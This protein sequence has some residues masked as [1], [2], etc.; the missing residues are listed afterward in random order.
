MA[1]ADQLF[2]RFG[3]EVPAGTV[4]FY[5]NDP[6]QEM[7][8]IQE[9]KVKIS[10]KVRNT[11]KTLAVLGK[12]EFFGE[13]AILNNKPRSA[14]AEV[15]EDS[16][17]LVIDRK[18]FESMIR[19]NAEI[20]LRI[21]KK[22]AARLQEADNQIENLMIRDNTA[23]V[24]DLLAR[25]TKDR[26]RETDQGVSLDVTFDDLAGMAGMAKDQILSILDKLVR[27][28]IIDLRDGQILITNR[29]HLDRF[30]KYLEMKEM[31]GEL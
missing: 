16:K 3:R 18:T 1:G 15:I 28:Q 10:K 19:G 25:L 4:L 30:M 22:L 14:T 17:I 12:G 2:Q 11:E 7:F 5:E 20:A 8:I 9:G 26:G 31:F 24:V 6:G 29:E 27:V 21:I 13:M 23:R